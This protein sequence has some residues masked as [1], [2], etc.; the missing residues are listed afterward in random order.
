MK[1]ELTN[2]ELKIIDIGLDVA[3]F[4]NQ[5]PDKG[6]EGYEDI[7]LLRKKLGIYTEE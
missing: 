1:V 4:E 5:L 7:V 6:E 2:N 3:C